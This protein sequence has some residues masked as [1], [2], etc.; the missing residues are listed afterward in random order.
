MEVERACDAYLPGRAAI[1]GI[2][3]RQNL[4]E[5]LVMMPAVRARCGEAA[6]PRCTGARL[7]PCTHAVVWEGSGTRE[8]AVAEPAATA[9][10]A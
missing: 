2:A 1:V 6:S 7:R 10:R 8:R 3:G 5:A 9:T 4:W